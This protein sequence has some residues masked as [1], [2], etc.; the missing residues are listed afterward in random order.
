[1][2]E[3]RTFMHY[4]SK[5]PAIKTT[6]MNLLI[7][8]ALASLAMTGCNKQQDA[9]TLIADARNY[10]QK[11]DN[12][13]AI[14]QLK[15]SLQQN[16][17]DPEARYLLGTIYNKTGDLQS[18]EKELRKALSLG[19]SPAKV[20]PDLGQAMLGLGQFQ[21]LLD[22]TQ[23]LS[24]N[25]A[26]AE[27]STLRGNALL[28]L[29]KAE[30]AKKLFEQALGKQPHFPDAIVGMA[31]YSLMQQDVDTAIRLS[32][33]AVEKNPGSAEAWL[34]KGD[35]LRVLGKSD[36]AI[37]AYNEVIKIKPNS[38]AAYLNKA[39]LE[40]GAGKFDS[41]KADVDA[42]RKVTPGSLLVFYTQALL[43]YSQG[44]YPAALESL[45][46]VFRAAPDHLPSLL[47]GGA[48][49]LALGSLPQAET[50]LKQYLEKDP[51]NLY[52]RKLLASVLLKNRE[53]QRAVSVLA[54]ALKNKNI[55]PDSQLFALAGEA[56]MQ[57]RDF[58]KATEYFEK[59]SSMAPENATLHAALSMSKMGQGDSDRAIAELEAARKLDPQSSQAGILLAMTHLR[60]KEFDKALAVA[61]AVEKE[62]PDNPLVQNLKGGI[63]LKKKD[64]VAARASFEKA[65]SLQPSYFPAVTNL[66]QLDIQENKPEVAKQRFEALL[67]KDKKNI[68]A[69]TAL[70]GIAL[71][72][73]DNKEATMWLERAHKENPNALE[74][75][76]LL[77]AHYLRV[78]EKQKAFS[79]VEK[80]RGA[81]PNNPDVLD[82][83][84]Q[85]QFANDDK[86]G[87]LE[88]YN[89]LAAMLPGSALAQFRIAAIHIATDNL[90]AA[91]DA[92]KKAL[93][94][95][96]DYLDAQLTQILL[97]T[98]N[99]NYAGALAVS[100]QIQKQYPKL[101]VGYVAEG[102]L[103]LKRNNPALASKAYEHALSLGKDPLLLMKL[104]AALSQTGKKGE[105]NSRL[106]HWLK[107]NPG[108]ATVRMYLAEAYMTDRE[109]KPAIEQYQTVL[110]THPKNVAALNNLAMALQQNKDSQALEYAEKAHQL[111]ADN[112]SVL[113]TLG[114]ILIAQGNTARGLPLLRKAATLAPDMP[115]I[116]YHLALGLI[117]TDDRA[118]ARKELE[119]L[120]ASGKNF[121][122]IGEARALLKQIQ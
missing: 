21:Q 37:A 12:K 77:E 44:K 70:A 119:Q 58:E 5:A 102:D 94:L 10:Q 112:P 86:A 11:G 7:L 75:A 121:A 31:K 65:L 8:A 76:L 80:L 95:K 66:A 89:K 15:N 78:G 25:D 16:P 108:D 54:P 50:N 39:F 111:A 14:I 45:Q 29:N 6:L 38:T 84:A 60:L 72:R 4:S 3:E 117:K 53:G 85:A 98:R 105:A 62:H 120:I 28:S 42:A 19:M 34:F 1:M 9:Q 48:V 106:V 17:N 49:Q 47:L 35:L 73:Q 41:A 110:R 2:T 59:A 68:Q 118:G 61:K 63:Y 55:Q 30:D 57:T 27:I 88:S 83:L 101:P 56:Y 20:W 90:P 107:E 116:R 36:P 79:L 18:A 104:H 43:D 109:I 97:E 91:S 99:K 82:F 24:G 115:D 71:N 23:K 93:A 67:Q 122:D 32:D 69:M 64:A 46:Q 96:P 114:S 40:I 13:A 26:S 100:K 51:G 33:E 52:A 103:E 113:D 74:P 22:D 87:A 92:L 81:Y